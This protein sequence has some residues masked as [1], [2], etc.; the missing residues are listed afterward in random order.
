MV[1]FQSDLSS[2]YTNNKP[3]VIFSY[4]DGYIHFFLYSL[5]LR[6]IQQ[7]VSLLL[8]VR[9]TPFTNLDTLINRLMMRRII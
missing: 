6:V 7:H 1:Y 8:L 4:T 3:D 9:P 2:V 5:I